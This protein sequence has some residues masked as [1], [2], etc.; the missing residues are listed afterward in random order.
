MRNGCIFILLLPSSSMHALP[1]TMPAFY[2]SDGEGTV[3]TARLCSQV[4]FEDPFS[5]AVPLPSSLSDNCPGLDF[6]LCSGGKA[7]GPLLTWMRL[8]GPVHRACWVP[9]GTDHS[10]TSLS[11]Q[12]CLPHV[13]HLAPRVPPKSALHCALTWPPVCPLKSHCPAGNQDPSLLGISIPGQG[14]PTTVHHG[15]GSG[16]GCWWA[17]DQ[18]RG[19]KMN[20][21]TVGLVADVGQ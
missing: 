17:T 10:P 19:G 2:S 15:L 11:A 14:D 18:G 1:E 7:P 8:Q 21:G 6:A 9:E 12:S 20:M 4:P 13:F 16:Q 3:V 5:R